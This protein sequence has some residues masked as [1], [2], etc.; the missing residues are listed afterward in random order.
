MLYYYVAEDKFQQADQWM[1]RGL[2]RG[3]N[4]PPR[5]S[6]DARGGGPPTIL[7]IATARS[8]STAVGNI[9]NYH[10]DALYL[11]EPFKML[12]LGDS[13]VQADIFGSCDGWKR[14]KTA[15]KLVWPK[16]HRPLWY[17]SA[18][19]RLRKEGTHNVVE[20]TSTRTKRDAASE[21]VKTKVLR[22]GLD[23]CEDETKVTAIKT[24][25]FNEVDHD[26]ADRLAKD[27]AR[28][29]P[30]VKIVLVLRHPGAVWA[31]QRGMG[32]RWHRDDR[33]WIRDICD[34]TYEAS[35]AI[36]NNFSQK[37]LLIVYYEDFVRRPHDAVEK[38]LVFAGLDHGKDVLRRLVREVSVKNSHPV[39]DRTNR[40]HERDLLG[41]WKQSIPPDL[42][43]M[44]RDECS[45]ACAFWG[46]TD[47]F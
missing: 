15:V 5:S 12:D 46:Y 23:M 47:C 26:R 45:V 1:L 36:T 40:K 20:E 19:D 35:K 11:F 3:G 44:L 6:S 8:G 42:R 22:L 30:N 32:W 21:E 28:R 27:I 2:K 17:V 24:I 25:R 14:R 4:P 9:F 10:Q 33:R 13:N 29:Y 34:Q 43:V 41:A 38:I 18:F 39:S 16:R 37:R 7:T 31:S